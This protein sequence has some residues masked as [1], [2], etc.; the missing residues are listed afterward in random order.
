VAIA[1]L[2]VLVY[3]RTVSLKHDIEKTKAE[4]ETVRVQNAE[5]KNGFYTAVDS[6]KLDELAQEKGLIYDKNPQWEF[7]S[8]L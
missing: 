6:R 5:L 1:S 2:Y 3:S 8:Q 7:A 4:L